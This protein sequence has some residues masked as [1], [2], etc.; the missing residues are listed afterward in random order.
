MRPDIHFD[1]PLPS[2]LTREAPPP[3]ANGGLDSAAD[4]ATASVIA[5]IIIL[6]LLTAACIMLGVAAFMILRGV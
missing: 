5:G 6:G 2:F 1:D 3:P 4:A